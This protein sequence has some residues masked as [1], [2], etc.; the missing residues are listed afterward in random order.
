MPITITITTITTAIAAT[1]ESS[2]C[3]DATTTTTT[4]TITIIIIASMFV[5]LVV[6]RRGLSPAVQA[7]LF[8]CFSSLGFGR[9]QNVAVGSVEHRI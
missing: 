8:I 9:S 3:R 2:L 6:E 5:N 4:I 1:E 7:A